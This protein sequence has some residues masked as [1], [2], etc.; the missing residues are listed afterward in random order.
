MELELPLLALFNVPESLLARLLLSDLMVEVA[1][2]PDWCWWFPR[3]LKVSD[4][5][6]GT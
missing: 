5:E 2:G 6:T 3:R 1:P 4:L